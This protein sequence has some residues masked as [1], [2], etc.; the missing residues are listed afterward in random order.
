MGHKNIEIILTCHYLQFQIIEFICKY[1]FLH[2]VDK[3]FITTNDSAIREYFKKFDCIEFNE[4]SNKSTFTSFQSLISDQENISRAKFQISIQNIEN[5]HSVSKEYANNTIF[6]IENF[7]FS[8]IRLFYLNKQCNLDTDS[9]FLL[10]VDE[11]HDANTIFTYF[12]KLFASFHLKYQLENRDSTVLKECHNL[13]PDNIL[14]EQNFSQIK[15]QSNFINQIS[16]PHRKYIIVT[17]NFNISKSL[18]RSIEELGDLG[19]LSHLRPFS[20]NENHISLN[21]LTD[22]KKNLINML[23]INP[24][25][26]NMLFQTLFCDSVDCF[27]FATSSHVSSEMLIKLTKFFK[28][29]CEY[30]TELFFYEENQLHSASDVLN[31]F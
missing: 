30:P 8:T 20:L 22:F 27:I 21:N 17:D 7:Q 9:R 19:L 12:G 14:V 24:Q 5:Y 23:I 6:L 3:I 28:K 11:I 1:R 26:L 16:R 29:N 18:A 15:S 31:V 2:Q 25:H 4:K 10:A 13:Q